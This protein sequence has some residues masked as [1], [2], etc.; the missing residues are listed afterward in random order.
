MKSLR[1][2]MICMR[3]PKFCMRCTAR[4]LSWPINCAGFGCDEV[5]TG[6]GRTGVVG[7][8]R[9]NKPG[10]GRTIALRADMDALPIEEATDV[11]YKSK[12]PGAMHACGH[13]GHTAML[14]GAAKYLAETRNFSGTAVMIFQPAEEGGNGAL[15][16]IEDGM[17]ERF[18]VEAVY[19]MHNDPTL[20]I[21]AFGIRT[22]AQLAAM[23][24]FTIAITG[25]GSHGAAPHLSH[26]P[27][28]VV[29]QLITSLQSIASPQC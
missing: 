29:G 2:G 20:P 6:L 25:K 17:M 24:K 5:V 1:G 3:I 10:P 26:D 22:G 13:D 8:I 9:G 16:M 28:I 23:D 18:G 21:G 11:P 4:R 27:V 19:G 7:I 12:T 15:A 14:L